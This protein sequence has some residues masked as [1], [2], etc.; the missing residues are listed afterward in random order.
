MVVEYKNGGKFAFYDGLKFTRDDKT[1]Y[2]LNSTIGK[3][4][5]RYIY[6]KEVSEIPKGKNF[7]IHHIDGNKANNLVSNLELTTNSKHTKHHTVMKM[8][9]NPDAFRRFQEAGIAKAPEWHASKE[10][11]EWHR[12][13]YERIK[14]NLQE[15]LEFECEQCHELYEAVDNGQ[16]RFCSNKCKSK[17]RRDSGLD[18]IDRKCAICDNVFKTH[19]YDKV[20]TCSKE[21]RAISYRQSRGWA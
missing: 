6:E 13:H 18:D 10:G 3:R 4:L 9:D 7:H 15:I 8:K 1:G 19:K 11:N 21:C 2:Y 20:K 17:W 16:N 12:R 5:H 14:G